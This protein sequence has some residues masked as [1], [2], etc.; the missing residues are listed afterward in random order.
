VK[1]IAL[2]L[3]ADAEA[4][5]GALAAARGAWGE[6]D[7]EGADQPFDLTAY[8]DE[9]MGK[10]LRRRLVSFQRL[11]RSED[12]AAA[13]LEAMAIE[14]S[15]ARGGNRRV[16]IDVG[17]LDLEKVVLASS[18][19]VW[20]RLHVGRGIHAEIVLRYAKGRFHPL[21]WSFPDFRDGRYERDL[22]AAR[23]RY[24][25]QREPRSSA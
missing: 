12:L 23:E 16:N 14:R 7:H 17:Y 20:H 15:L 6:L 9:E 3:W 5:S 11:T 22:V 8:Y 10:G 21:E 19:P 2:L 4:L 18:K 1:R 25:A 24:K 13:K